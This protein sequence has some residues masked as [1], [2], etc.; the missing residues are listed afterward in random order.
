MRWIF[1]VIT[2]LMLVACGD[3]EKEKETQKDQPNPSVENKSTTLKLRG[4]AQGTTYNITYIDSLARDFQ[5]AIDSI[6]VRMDQ[7][8]STY[9]PTSA[10]S[11]LNNNNDSLHFASTP[12]FN[13]VYTRSKEIAMATDMAFNPWVKPLVDYW[14]FGGEKWQGREGVDQA[15]IDSLLSFDNGL[16]S[17]YDI[18]EGLTIE[19]GQEI[20]VY[21][22]DARSQLDFNAIA[23]GYS[24]DVIAEMLESKGVSNYMVELGGE[25]RANGKNASEKYWRIGID[26]PIENSTAGDRELQA[27]V[28][29]KNRSLATSGNYRKFYEVDGM[30]Y[31]HTINP[32][33]GYPVKHNLL[34]ATVCA[35]NCASAD[36]FATAFMVMGVEK[37]IAFLESHQDSNIEVYL[38]WADEKGAWKTYVS[39]GLKEDLDPI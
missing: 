20:G 29:L 16:L 10:I 5:P 35:N 27:V 26:K 39:S 1:I 38:I 23:Q 6:L 22:R 7:S 15:V 32:K 30:K 13:E 18:P 25:V 21:K 28:E 12:F 11:T 8:L 19:E 9:L 37:T 33:T 34:S 31:A 2:S 14:G 36:A 17:L 4:E 24:V 3:G